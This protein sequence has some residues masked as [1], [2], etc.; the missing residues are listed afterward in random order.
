MAACGY[1][2]CGC[3]PANTPY[4]NGGPTI[5]SDI[6]TSCCGSLGDVGNGGG[7]HRRGCRCHWIILD[8]A[9]GEAGRLAIVVHDAVA[10]AEVQA[11]AVR[12]IVLRTTPVE[13]VIAAI[14][15]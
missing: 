7:S 11:P 9:D 4:S 1:R 13:A 2:A 10:T 12:G 8:A 3:T 5:G 14:E 6:S 15:Q